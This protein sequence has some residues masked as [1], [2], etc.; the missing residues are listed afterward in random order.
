MT[1]NKRSSEIL[2]KIIKEYI[3]SA[4]PIS[5]EYLK[6]KYRI[7]LSPA[8]LRNEMLKLTEEGYLYQPH[9]SAGRIP[10]D[11]GYRY[12]VDLLIEKE[13]NGIINERIKEEVNEIK[14]EVKDHL[15]YLREIN[16]FL[17]LSSSSFSVSY[18]AEEGF[19]LR[20]GLMKT[21]K[22]P[23]FSDVDYA[24]NFILMI[25]DFEK[26]ISE[27]ELNDSAINVYIGNE[28]PI[29]KF[30]DFGIIVSKC[31]FQDR[32]ALIAILGP[33][34]MAYNK[35]IPLINSIVKILKENN[36]D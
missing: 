6:K 30:K 17:A 33:K 13:I 16:R 24:R 3:V 12:F 35:S 10:T 25:E 31:V 11:K 28:I 21:F 2:N 34:R 7:D 1:L 29:K 27:F 36:Y 4:E 15:S 23:E 14:K 26:S 9:T 20:E 5:S 22:N 19:C 8:T 32:E 18:L